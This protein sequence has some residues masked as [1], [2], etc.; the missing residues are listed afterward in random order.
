MFAAAVSYAKIS[1]G[2]LVFVSTVVSGFPYRL[3]LRES[4]GCAVLSVVIP[5]YYTE[6]LLM[7]W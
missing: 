2:A 5:C 3:L 7:W 1:S 6:A 4:L